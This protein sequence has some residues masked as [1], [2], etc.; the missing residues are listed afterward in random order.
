MRTLTFCAIVIAVS[1]F[2]MAIEDVYGWS[3][4]RPHAEAAWGYA[5]KLGAELIGA[6]A[7]ADDVRPA[8]GVDAPG[9]NPT[10]ASAGDAVGDPAGD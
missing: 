9:S 4:V 7:R 1:T 6:E 2:T 5:H 10:G 3:K 8:E